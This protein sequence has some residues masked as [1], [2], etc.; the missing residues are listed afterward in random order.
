M[1]A[2]GVDVATVRNLL[3]HVSLDATN[4]YAQAG[5]WRRSERPSRR[6]M[7]RS[8]GARAPRWKQDVDLLAWLDSL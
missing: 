8:A 6:L 2:A 4:I 7:A 5:L 3:G 1:L